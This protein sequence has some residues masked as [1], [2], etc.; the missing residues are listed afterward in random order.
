MN[1]GF[2][3]RLYLLLA[4]FTLQFASLFGQSAEYV[5]CQLLVQIAPDH[6]PEEIKLDHPEIRFERL[7]ARSMNIWLV[8]FDDPNNNRIETVKQQL[9]AHP[10]IS[11]VQKNHKLSLRATPNDANFS[12]QWQYVNTGAGGGT[13]DADI[14]A[15]LAWDVTTGGLTP[16]GDTIVVAIVDDGIEETHSDMKANLWKNH[17]EI[18]GNG[19]DDDGNGYIDDVRGWNTSSNDDDVTD[20][21]WG[22]WH[23]TPVAGIVGAKGNNTIGVAGVN[24]DVKLMV[25]VG[26]DGTEANAIASY[27][28]ALDNRK[29]YNQ[30]NGTKGAYVVATNSSWGVDFG[31]AASAPLWC[32]FYDTLGKYGIVSAGATINGNQNVDAV[33]D[34]PTTCP[35][36]YLLAVTNMDRTDTKITDAGYG[37]THIDL[38]APGEDAYTVAIFD[39]YNGFG[40]TSGATPHVAGVIGLLHSV[41]CQAFNDLSKA[42]PDSAAKLIRQFILNGVDA[43]TSLS[44][45]TA[46]GGRLNANNAVQNLQ[47]WCALVTGSESEEVTHAFRIRKLYPNPTSGAVNI[48]YYSNS[49]GAIKLNVTDM[50][51]RTVYQKNYTALTG[52]NELDAN[53]DDL[54]S[55]MY[56]ILLEETETGAVSSWKLSLQH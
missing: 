56:Q 13:V 5:P 3:N 38:G 53:L 25:I 48:A 9:F 22:G 24:W 21:G 31:S 35:S 18:P 15:D 50:F 26:G 45:I 7:V 34:L 37:S 47:N 8:S 46:T 33:G 2:I 30:T 17:N 55:G 51:G 16:D 40:G 41:P 20:G 49:G 11:I 27:S 23:G 52:K 54:P 44:G 43:N 28:Y 42:D 6:Q 10:A 1:K 29:L 12:S 39:S 19:V 36:E 4:I 14:D 32:A